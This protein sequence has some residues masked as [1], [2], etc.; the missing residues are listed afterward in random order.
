MDMCF[1]LEAQLTGRASLGCR[2]KKRG[3][4]RRLAGD[5]RRGGGGPGDGN[6]GPGGGPK[7]GGRRE[8]W[9]ERRRE[10]AGR[11]GAWGQREERGWRSLC[12]PFGSHWKTLIRSWRLLLQGSSFRKKPRPK[13]EAT[14]SPSLL[15]S[16][17]PESPVAPGRVACIPAWG[18][19]WGGQ[20]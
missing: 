9:E 19:P 1:S 2:K 17:Y 20:G 7:D 5:W 11:L 14:A 18:R 8:R 15:A 12:I 10:R 4:R 6:R 13:T 3:E 16:W